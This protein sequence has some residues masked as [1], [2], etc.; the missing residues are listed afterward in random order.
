MVVM[1]GQLRWARIACVAALVVAGA[2]VNASGQERGPAKPAAAPPATAAK[3]AAASA[4]E[5]AAK[6][7][8]KGRLPA[9]FASVVNEKQRAEIYDLQNRYASQIKQLQAQ[10]DALTKE[11][12]TAIDAVLT[13]EQLA[14]VNKK[15]EAAKASRSSR[16]KP[17]STDAAAP[18][19]SAEK[20]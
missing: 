15:R 3:D 19:A 13:A 9:F 17:A 2:A 16:T 20:E 12:D 6:E 11:R 7:T 10:L 14:E 5:P 1:G 8:L 4:K 18:P